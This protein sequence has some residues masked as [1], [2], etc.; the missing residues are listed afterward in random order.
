MHKF[1]PSTNELTFPCPR[2]WEFASKVIKNKEKI[3]HITTIRLAETVG[4]GAAV[5]FA[6]YSQIYQNL[7]TIEE[8]LKNPKSGW[9]VPKEPSE[10]YAVT[11]M[12][13]HNSTLDNI[14]K[15]ITAMNRLPEEFRVIVLK[16][17][18]KIS[19]KLKNHPVI[20]NWIANNAHILFS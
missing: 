13:S 7:P 6:T 4:E 5:E 1:N 18:Y 14:D 9:K 16:D 3:D 10:Q 20:K 17:I 2:T 19:P 15:I 11:T 8:I 12:L